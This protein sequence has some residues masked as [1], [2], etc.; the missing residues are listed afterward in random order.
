MG[1]SP[2]QNQELF[3]LNLDTDVLYIYIYQWTRWALNEMTN[4]Q[5]GTVVMVGSKFS[6]TLSETVYI[7][8]KQKKPRRTN[9][10]IHYTCILKF[11]NNVLYL[12]T[13]RILHEAF[14]FLSAVF[15]SKIV[16]RE[17]KV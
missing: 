11:I 14:F 17:S 13:V 9:K 10:Q 6:N 5:K 12:Y 16:I 4:V 1:I 8:F 2:D 15:N 7:H 3:Y